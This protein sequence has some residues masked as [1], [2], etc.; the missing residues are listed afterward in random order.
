MCVVPVVT[1]V[2]SK[3]DHALSNTS[4]TVS[5]YNRCLGIPF[6]CA[7][8]MHQDLVI[9]LDTF[10]ENKVKFY[11]KHQTHKGNFETKLKNEHAVVKWSST[12]I[13]VECTLRKGQ[14]GYYHLKKNW[15][16]D[17]LS[18]LQS[19][20]D[21]LEE[22]KKHVNDEYWD[23]MMVD[24]RNVNMKHPDDVML[25]PNKS[26]REVVLVGKARVMDDSWNEICKSIDQSIKKVKDSKA[27]TTKSQSLKP[28]QA[29]YLYASN[30]RSQYPDLSIKIDK[31][32]SQ[33][34][35]K[36][37]KHEVDKCLLEMKDVIG[38]ICERKVDIES[39]HALLLKKDQVKSCIERKMQKGRLTD[40][41]EVNSDTLTVYADEEDDLDKMENVIT[42]ALS[43][44]TLNMDEGLRT[45][46]K[47]SEWHNEERRLR[48]KFHDCIEFKQ[49][50][51]K[52]L[53]E[54][55][56][57]AENEDEV[58]DMLDQ[59]T[60]KN[61]VHEETVSID[62]PVAVF[63]DKHM[64]R[65]IQEKMDDLRDKDLDV[66]WKIHHQGN[67]WLKGEDID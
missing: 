5:P 55:F 59:F 25:L 50:K 57:L 19:C 62:P 15:R 51:Q 27:S 42:N 61:T 37:P 2:C 33:I 24:I 46:L 44:I 12:P 58:S 54:V 9:T 16:K 45:A 67:I 4:I 26:K 8:D 41:W 39:E 13:Q 17:V 20:M 34:E 14:P 64:F 43:K 53:L 38:Q 66:K 6:G 29:K 47:T 18:V 31:S 1:R 22:R 63:M 28:F 65:K 49:D 30:F 32:N 21:S 35:I 11:Q 3:K 7:I 23:T 40:V 48:Q 52:K 60:N 36:G 10:D 56:M